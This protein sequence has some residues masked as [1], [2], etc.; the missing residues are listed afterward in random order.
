MSRKRATLEQAQF[1]EARYPTGDVF[2]SE[3]R[4][5]KSELRGAVFALALIVAE[6]PKADEKGHAALA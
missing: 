1:D 5:P 2:A 4:H 6:I 3:N